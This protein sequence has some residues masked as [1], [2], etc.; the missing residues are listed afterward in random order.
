MELKS[1]L[2]G[3]LILVFFIIFGSTYYH[4]IEP[5]NDISIKI[6]EGNSMYPLIHDGE[7]RNLFI[8]Y[9]TKQQT[10]PKKGDIVAYNYAGKQK[11]LIKVIQATDSDIVSFSGN[12]LIINDT[13]LKNS[14]GEEYIFS[15]KEIQ[16]LS[17]Y[18]K[19]SHI[20]KNSYFIFGYNTKNS[21]DSRNF[22][23]ISGEDILGKFE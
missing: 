16:I 7:K 17:L 22:G 23:A 9:Y 3:G 19:D 11:A 15:D 6:I 4:K 21:L 5:K 20:P 8:D 18:I 10:L 14:L 2:T 13:I 12:F 1:I